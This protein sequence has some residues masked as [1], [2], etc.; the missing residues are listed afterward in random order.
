M[1]N[2]TPSSSHMPPIWENVS[3]GA[4]GN[5]HVGPILNCLTGIFALLLPK[6]MLD[7]YTSG[8]ETKLAPYWNFTILISILPNQIPSKLDEYVR[9]TASYRFLRWRP[10]RRKYISGFLF[11]DVSHLRRSKPC[12]KFRHDISIHG[13]DTT[14]GF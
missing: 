4:P 11:R 7:I 1:G 6:S 9:V 5:Y 10:R 14:S 3:P 2:T 8:F 13:Y 12:T